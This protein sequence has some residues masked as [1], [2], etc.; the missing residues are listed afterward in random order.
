METSNSRHRLYRAWSRRSAEAALRFGTILLTIVGLALAL[1]MARMANAQQSPL[2]AS[3]PTPEPAATVRSPATIPSPEGNGAQKSITQELAKSPLTISGK[4]FASIF[5]RFLHDRSD[6]PEY[7]PNLLNSLKAAFATNDGTEADKFLRGGHY[8]RAIIAISLNPS[9]ARREDEPPLS[10][11]LYLQGDDGQ[12]ESVRYNVRD[13]AKIFSRRDAEL[14]T[15]EREK[16]PYNLAS[17]GVIYDYTAGNTRRVHLLI[18]KNLAPAENAPAGRIVFNPGMLNNPA[19]VQARFR[20]LTG[21]DDIDSDPG[22]MKPGFGENFIALKQLHIAKIGMNTW[23]LIARF[24]EPGSSKSF[25]AVITEAASNPVTGLLGTDYRV[26]SSL[27]ATPEPASSD[28]ASPPPTV[29]TAHEATPEPASSNE[30]SP[31]PAIALHHEATP[32][33]AASPPPTIATVHSSIKD[34][35]TQLKMDSVIA[36]SGNWSRALYERTGDNY[37]QD[38][39]SALKAAYTLGDVQPLKSLLK[40]RGLNRV[41]MNLLLTKEKI[42]IAMMVWNGKQSHDVATFDADPTT[43]FAPDQAAAL[44]EER[45]KNVYHLDVA[46][47]ISY[48]VDDKFRKWLLVYQYLNP[49]QE[50]QVHELSKHEYVA[51]NIRWTAT[52]PICEESGRADLLAN[53]G[54]HTT[55][56][57]IDHPGLRAG[58]VAMNMQERENIIKIGPN[59]CALFFNFMQTP[60]VTRAATDEPTPVA[61]ASPAN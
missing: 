45:K 31:P 24:M 59:T 36:L 58:F 6:P 50:N 3:T 11:A 25:S 16:N 44:I 35:P 4:L 48:G 41:I 29:A 52:L 56:L 34:I 39:S 9:K 46:M 40:Q 23:A 14:L 55:N 20:A 22:I 33:D 49:D 51:C 47:Q 27:D 18:P 12:F 61:I 17:I 60:A 57:A 26:A 53:H 32:S 54:F 8:T 7:G 5:D 30:A 28:A 21:L 1:L 19:L 43:I 13:L 42:T 15:D 37:Y 2:N 10:V 38:I